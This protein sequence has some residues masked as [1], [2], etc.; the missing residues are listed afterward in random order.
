VRGAD[1]ILERISDL[2]GVGVGEVTS[3]GK[4]SVEVVRCIGCCAIAPAIKIGEK[5]HGRIRFSEIEK[6]LKGYT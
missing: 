4:F 2:L 5:V 1:R 6:I 3:D